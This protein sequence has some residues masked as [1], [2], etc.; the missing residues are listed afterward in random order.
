MHGAKHS[1]E[2]L[3]HNPKATGCYIF[4]LPKSLLTQNLEAKNEFNLK[5]E[6]WWM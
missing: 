1:G 5:H 3:K 6:V 2:S 4:E